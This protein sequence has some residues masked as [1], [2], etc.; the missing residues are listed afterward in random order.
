MH[1]IF[2][3]ILMLEIRPIKHLNRFSMKKCKHN[4]LCQMPQCQ[5]L[6]PT[7]C[8]KCHYTKIWTN[9]RIVLNAKNNCAKCRKYCTKYHKCAKYHGDVPNATQQSI[10]LSIS[11]Y[12]YITIYLYIYISIYLYIYLYK[13]SATTQQIPLGIFITISFVPQDVAL[14]R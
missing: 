14:I 4:R 13:I 8:A 5:N 2:P 10:Y 6:A 9:T 11:L 7:D 3:N 12:L 1:T